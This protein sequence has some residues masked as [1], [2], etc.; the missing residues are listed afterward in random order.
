MS[1]LF[2]AQKF[3]EGREWHKMGRWKYNIFLISTCI[4]NI[5]DIEYGDA[6][7]FAP[8]AYGVFDHHQF[9]DTAGWKKNVEQT[10]QLFSKDIDS[11]VTEL[12][13]Q[14]KEHVKL[15]EGFSPTKFDS[16]AVEKSLHLVSFH[17]RQW[18][19][20]MLADEALSQLYPKSLPNPFTLGGRDW[21]AQAI[22]T[23]VAL[24]KKL[25]PMI[26]ESYHLL[27]MA[28][29]C[30]KGKN[31][32]KE[33]DAHTRKYGWMNSLCWWD[34]PFSKEHYK[35]Q[36]LGLANQEPEKLLEE[37]KRARAEQYAFA[38]KLLTELEKIHPNAF[39]F[40]DIIRELTDLKE[41]NW[42]VVSLAGT[43]VRSLLRRAAA[44]H[45]LSPGQ[46]MQLAKGEM[47]FL[48]ERNEFPAGVDENELNQRLK[49]YS[50]LDVQGEKQ[51]LF[52]GNEAEELLKIMDKAPPQLDELKGMPVWEGI[53]RGRVC[54]LSTSDEIGR[55]K[56]GEI[57]VCPMSD[58][59]YMPAIK[60]ASAIVADQGGLLCHA[61]IV[62]R[63][64]QIPCVVG[65]EYATKLLKD[66][67]EVEVDAV[68]GIIRKI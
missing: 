7:P 54:K 56:P 66:G 26:E 3:L 2:D 53:V 30:S 44:E 60:K 68:K 37:K 57:L 24:P 27:E 61:A 6:L 15:M 31:V 4:P 51:Q 47:I 34:E 38:E 65:T 39:H 62:A 50:I 10:R 23:K 14:V 58:P 16:D 11:P 52:S 64:L 48:L 13:R 21:D 19:E 67:D 1:E 55:M 20:I 17:A 40:L 25:F 29:A 8:L 43:R 42:D 5:L 63:E 22:L 46:F 41:E 32:E 33:L 18:Y 49:H 35:K 36:V 59:D 12:K 28:I 45:H 9:V